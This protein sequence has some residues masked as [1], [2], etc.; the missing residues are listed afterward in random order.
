MEGTG[1]GTGWLGKNNLYW[2]ETQ[3]L[4]YLMAM[5]K[6]LDYTF[7]KIVQNGVWFFIGSDG[8]I[9]PMGNTVMMMDA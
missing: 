4:R 5:P 7:E 6:E 8:S 9:Y 1:E 2:K 3:M